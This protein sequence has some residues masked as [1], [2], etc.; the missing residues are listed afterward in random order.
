VTG[1]KEILRMP[2]LTE[3]IVLDTCVSVTV[4]YG[5]VPSVQVVTSSIVSVVWLLFI[6]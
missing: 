3:A 4:N 6:T 5:K 2:A 1:F